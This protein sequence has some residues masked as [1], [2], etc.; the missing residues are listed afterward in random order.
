M[1]ALV[2][3]DVSKA[4]KRYPTKWAR[5]WEWI[6][7]KTKHEKYWVL[8]N[9]SFTIKPGEAVGI[10]GMNGAG[11]STLLKIIAGTTF[12]TSGRVS[13]EGR[14]AAL[15]ELGM[16]FHSNFTGRQNVS[17]VGQLLGL[18]SDEIARCMPDIENFAEIGDY[19]D[20]PVR[21]YSSGMQMRLAFSV[22]TAVRPDVLIVDEAL[23]V[24]DAYFQHK[25]FDRIRQFV[26]QGTTLLLVSHDKQA[27]QSICSR[28]ILLNNGCIAMEGDPESVMNYYN[29]L[30]ADRG[31]NEPGEYA[32]KH[33]GLEIISGTGDAVVGNF[34]LLNE[35][36]SPADVL[37]VSEVAK[38][39]IRI[40]IRK[41]IE[42]LVVG[43][44]IKNRFGISV[45]GTTSLDSGVCLKN[46][47]PGEFIDFEI[48]F[49]N[50]LGP[51]SYSI[52]IALA[53]DRSHVA[54]NYEW[55]D[56]IAV[57]NVING[58]AHEF[59]GLVNLKNEMKYIAGKHDVE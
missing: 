27:I 6:T 48:K 49:S 35:A 46:F 33:Q 41:K 53:K 28:A 23:S 36:G 2:V 32:V 47:D 55:K 50:D 37:Y 20:R 56:R 29:A 21:T 25:S 54:G 7:G 15:L 10:I 17:M 11:K 39:K 57:F 52:S 12:P 59:L 1:S 8:K 34:Q 4:Y 9:I 14:V 40:D 31:G 58:G 22:A 30:L 16:G 43:F 3:A 44:L 45:Y 38:I 26:R 24:G 18:K 5:A 51:G 13:S 42:S 19:I